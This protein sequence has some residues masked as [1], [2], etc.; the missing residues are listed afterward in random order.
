MRSPGRSGPTGRRD[1]GSLRA[2]RP[3]RGRRREP[4]TRASAG[5]PRTCGART[6]WPPSPGSGRRPFPGA[7]PRHPLAERSQP[8]AALLSSPRSSASYFTLN[9]AERG[10]LGPFFFHD[11]YDIN[12]YTFTAQI[13]IQYLLRASH[14]A[15]AE[16]TQGS[17]Q[18]GV[19]VLTARSRWGGGE[20]GAQVDPKRRPVTG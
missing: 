8:T 6:R 16:A 4:L 10:F 11:I 5:S 14:Q 12:I 13:F 9:K 15:E 19:C 3:G 18:S 17:R 20:A 7:A 1:C 2:G